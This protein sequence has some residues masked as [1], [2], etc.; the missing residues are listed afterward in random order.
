M[1]LVLV[2]ST[3]MKCIFLVVMMM[4]VY[5]KGKATKVHKF[6][7]NYQSSIVYRN[8]T[9][10]QNNKLARTPR[11]KTRHGISHALSAAKIIAKKGKRQRSNH[12]LSAAKKSARQRTRQRQL[13]RKRQR[14]QKGPNKNIG[15]RGGQGCSDN[16]RK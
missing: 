14:Q 1:H 13:E 8:T 10:G 11:Q 7:T 4:A 2:A 16:V 5:Q 15:G 6:N 3:K 9:N 12:I